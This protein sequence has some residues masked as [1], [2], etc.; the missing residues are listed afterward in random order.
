MFSLG[1]TLKKVGFRSRLE[2]FLRVSSDVSSQK[3]ISRSDENIFYVEEGGFKNR[4]F[5]IG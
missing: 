2:D 3:I 1:D 5:K 4:Y